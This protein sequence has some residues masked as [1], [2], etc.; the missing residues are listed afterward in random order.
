MRGELV[1]SQASSAISLGPHMRNHRPEPLASVSVLRFSPTPQSVPTV[2]AS[3]HEW[4]CPLFTRG[5]ETGHFYSRSPGGG[6]LGRAGQ[7]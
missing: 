3:L 5:A 1:R 7:L 6:L 2:T 4:R